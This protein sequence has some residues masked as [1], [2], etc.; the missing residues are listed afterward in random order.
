[1][2]YIVEKIIKKDAELA[3]LEWVLRSPKIIVMLYDE[4][5][6]GIKT[7]SADRTCLRRRISRLILK[8]DPTH[9]RRKRSEL[10]DIILKEILDNNIDD[11]KKNFHKIVAD[12]TWEKMYKAYG[13]GE[14]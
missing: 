7:V 11:I 12:Y 14:K 3:F 13:K 5:Y 10:V 2:Y 1:M 6:L 4:I 9:T 8:Y